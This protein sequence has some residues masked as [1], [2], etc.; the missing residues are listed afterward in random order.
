MQ[1]YKTLTMTIFGNVHQ[2]YT[3]NLLYSNEFNKTSINPKLSVVA[4]TCANNI[5]YVNRKWKILP[6]T[7]V[8]RL[9]SIFSAI[10][11][12]VFK[13]KGQHLSASKSRSL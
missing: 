2:K 5:E 3:F 11:D 1:V 10:N 7:V 6:S 12:K 9:T 13:V 4:C 8:K